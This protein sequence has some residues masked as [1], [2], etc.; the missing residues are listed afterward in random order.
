MMGAPSVVSPRQLRELSIRLAG[1]ALDTQ[2]SASDAEASDP[3]QVSDN[4]L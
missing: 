3:A 1:D 2:K 4:D